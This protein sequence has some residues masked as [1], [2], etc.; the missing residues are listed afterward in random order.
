MSDQ[1]LPTKDPDPLQL[2][3]IVVR[4]RELQGFVG[5]N[6]V[7]AAAYTAGLSVDQWVG[8]EHGTLNLSMADYDR[9]AGVLE[10]DKPEALAA[11]LQRLGGYSF[12]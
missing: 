1:T 4:R 11:R 6:G 3:A 2:A 12:R 9:M 7:A 10:P 8:V 5:E